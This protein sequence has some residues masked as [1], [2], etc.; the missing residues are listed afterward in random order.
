ML[1]KVH[2]LM[3]YSEVLLAKRQGWGFTFGPAALKLGVRL[4]GDCERNISGHK[5]RGRKVV[6]ICQN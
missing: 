4:V 3:N 6:W 1:T 5:P 2:I